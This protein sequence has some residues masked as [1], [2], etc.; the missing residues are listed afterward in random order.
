MALAP[1][2]KLERYL[3]FLFQVILTTRFMG[4][5]KPAASEEIADLMDAVHNLPDL[6]R[7]WELFDESLFREYLGQFD[8]KWP[9]EGIQISLVARLDACLG[10]R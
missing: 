2:D 5:N 7:N 8:K 6:L 10:S 9:P 4:W 3:E 1:A